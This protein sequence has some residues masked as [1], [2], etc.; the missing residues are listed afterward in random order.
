[1]P[2]SRWLSQLAINQDLFDHWTP[3]PRGDV[4]TEITSDPNNELT[5]MNNSIIATWCATRW[6]D[7]YRFVD[8]KLIFWASKRKILVVGGAGESAISGET[9]TPRGGISFAACRRSKHPGID[10]YRRRLLWWWDIKMVG[11]KQLCVEA[12]QPFIMLTDDDDGAI[13][14]SFIHS[15]VWVVYIMQIWRGAI[16]TFLLGL[17]GM[18]EKTRIKKKISKR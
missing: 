14:H 6:R 8:G 13:V 16:L 4:R 5:T 1:M 3:Y 17:C 7:L 11:V 12:F 9:I 2:L 10:N 15:V 18:G